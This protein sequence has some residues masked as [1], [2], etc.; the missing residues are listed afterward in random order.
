MQ[1]LKIKRTLT[2]FGEF[3]IEV[4]DGVGHDALESAL[5]DE[6]N[7]FDLCERK[8]RVSVYD[9]HPESL[10]PNEYTI[11]EAKEKC[12]NHIELA[13]AEIAIEEDEIQVPD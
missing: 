9:M 13:D 5:L 8:G 3:T 11:T 1:L 4:P 12:R 6:A 2:L 7:L 10:T